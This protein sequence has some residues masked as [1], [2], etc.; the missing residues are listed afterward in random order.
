[1]SSTLSSKTFKLSLFEQDPDAP[2][3]AVRRVVINADVL[4][5]SKLSTGDLVA[6]TGSENVRLQFRFIEFYALDSCLAFFLI[7][8]LPWAL[9]GLR[10]SSHRTVRTLQ[11]QRRE[12]EVE[13]T[14]SLLLSNPSRRYLHQFNPDAWGSAWINSSRRASFRGESVVGSAICPE[15]QGSTRC[16]P[17]RDFH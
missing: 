13:P 11:P 5:A 12:Y 8:N 17:M 3:R 7:R 2:R 15:R 14:S 1:M 6:V 16:A 10:W 9:R 4:K